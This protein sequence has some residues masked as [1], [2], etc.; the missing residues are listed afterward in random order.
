MLLNNIE[1]EHTNMRDVFVTRASL[2]DKPLLICESETLTYGDADE[3]SNRIAN[4][5]SGFGIAKGDVVA[6][7]M[8]N[9]VE[10]AAVWL[11]CVKLGA[12]FASLNVSLA[13][14]EAD[15]RRQRADRHLRPGP[16][17]VGRPTDRG[18]VARPGEG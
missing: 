10:H 16:A 18:V 2:G 15:L 4:S 5:L 9:S 11:A 13:P 17:R 12:I 7:L 3:Q 6:T 14:K 1:L 8:Y